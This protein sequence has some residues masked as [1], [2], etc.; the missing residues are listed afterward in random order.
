[1]YF[2]ELNKRSSYKSLEVTVAPHLSVPGTHLLIYLKLWQ[3]DAT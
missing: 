1:M 3:I 2:G